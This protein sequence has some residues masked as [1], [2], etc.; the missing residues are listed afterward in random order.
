MSRVIKAAELAKTARISSLFTLACAFSAA[1]IE[2]VS[3]APGVQINNQ[4]QSYYLLGEDPNTVFESISNISSVTTG[5]E[6]G[7]S[8]DQSQVRD[9]AANQLVYFPHTLTNEGNAPDSYDLLAANLLGDQGDLANL[10][11]YLDLNGNGVPDTGELSITQTPVMQAGDELSL[12]V[13]GEV[14][15]GVASGDQFVVDLSATSVADALETA[16]NTDAI[17]VIDGALLR[18]I[19]TSSFAC[20]QPLDGG[21]TF[22]YSVTWTNS[23]DQNPQERQHKVDGSLNSGVLIEDRL[24]ADV[25]LIAGQALSFV[26][27]AAQAVVMTSAD[28]AD[29][30]WISYSSW[31][32]VSHLARI[33]LLIP[34]TELRPTQ[35][36]SF[37]FEVRVSSSVTQNT[38]LEN[39]IVVDEDGD[40]D[41]EFSS[42]IVCNTTNG[43]DAEIRFLSPT[44]ENIIGGD[45]PDFE[46]ASDFSDTLRYR[47]DAD[48]ADYDAT[49]DG[50]YV[51]LS[52]TSVP[53]ENIQYLEDGTRQVVVS[54]NSEISGESVPVLVRETEPGS[55]VY[56]NILPLVLSTTQSATGGLCGDV[57]GE[58]DY[59]SVPPAECVLRSGED[60]SLTVTFFDEG[61]GEVIDDASIVDP[62]GIVFDAITLAPIQGAEVRVFNAINNGPAGLQGELANDPFSA[63]NDPLVIQV[64]DTSGFY[65][66]PFMYPGSYYM[67][68]TLPANSGYAWPSI[69]NPLL[70]PG[71]DVSDFSYGIDGFQGA[72]TDSGVFVLDA[73]NP[74]VSVDFP[75]DP[76]EME[77]VISG[78]VSCDADLTT[79]DPIAYVASFANSGNLTPP[80]RDIQVDGVT[81]TGVVVQAMIPLSTAFD[82]AVVPSFSPVSAELILKLYDGSGPDSWVDYDTWIAQAPEDRLLVSSIGLL[83][84]QADLEPSGT[85]GVLGEGGDL[86]YGVRIVGDITAGTQIINRISVD[87]D[88]N[89]SAD[90]LSADDL[91]DACE[92]VVG[93]EPEIRFLGANNGGTDPVFDQLTSLDDVSQYLLRGVAADYDHSLD[94]VYI[95]LVSTSILAEDF[96]LLDDGRR[97]IRVQVDSGLTGDSIQM[98][99]EETG[100]ASGIYRSIR[101][102]VLDDSDTGNGAVCHPSI[103]ADYV[104]D[105]G[106]ECILTSSVNDVLTVTFLHRFEAGTTTPES[107][108]T[109]DATV[110]PIGFVFFSEAPFDP[111]AGAIVRIY[112][113]GGIP[114]LKTEPTRA[115]ATAADTLVTGPIATAADG[116]FPFPSLPNGAYFLEVESTDIY[117]FPS[118]ANRT[119][120]L[121]ES[122]YRTGAFSYGND[123]AA[124]IIT[125]SDSNPFEVF[126]I[127]VDVIG[128]DAILVV[129]KTVNQNSVEIGGLLEYVVS[130]S[131]VGDGPAS[132]VEVVDRL[133]F[134]FK[135]IENTLRQDQIQIADPNGA[136]APDLSFDVGILLADESIEFRYVL[137]A[138]SGALDSDGINTAQANG[139]ALI[140]PIVSNEARVQVDIELSGVLSEKG[141]I[142]GKIFVDAD[143]NNIQSQGEWPVGGVALYLEDGTYAITDENGQY[144]IYGINPGSHSIK[145]DS[146]TLPEGLKLKPIDNRNLADPDSRLV[147]LING[148]FHRADFA[149]ACPNPSEA[150]FVY[151]QVAARNSSI[152]G[153]WL[154]A[155]SA[156]FDQFERA[157]A[158]AQL[159]DEDLSSGTIFSS[160][161]LDSSASLVSPAIGIRNDL[162][163]TA[164]SEEEVESAVV[165]GD[166]VYEITSEEG[167][168]GLWLWPKDEISLYGRFVVAV[169]D[170][171][172][173]D[174]YLNGEKVSRSQL[175]EEAHNTATDVQ[176]LAWYGL[177]LTSGEN[178]VEVKTQDMFG[179]ERVMLSK[180]FVNPS[181][182]VEL[183]VEPESDIMAA[184]GGRSVMPIQI[185]VLDE[186]GYK[187][188]GLHYVTVE[189]SDGRILGE[190]LQPDTAGFQ[191]RLDRGSARV[192][193]QSSNNT[194]EVE[195]RVSNDEFDQSTF[196][197]LVAAQRSL[198][199][200]GIASA[201]AASCSIDSEGFAP[202]GDECMDSELSN[203]V[204]LFMK[205]SVRGNLFLTLSYDS[206]KAG[207]GELLRDI[208]PDEY[209]PIFGDSSVR[210]YEA[211]SRSKL[212]AKLEMDRS[213][214]QWGDFS[215]DSGSS[216]QDLGRVQRSLTGFSAALDQGSLQA[217]VFIAEVEDTRD[218]IEI[219]GNGTA[220]LFQI[221]AAPIVR[222]SEIIEWVV[223]DRENIGLVLTAETLTR[224]IDYSI[225]HISG[226][227]RFTRAIP[228]VD[229]DLNPISLRISYDLEGATGSDL[230]AGA[231]ASYDISDG[232]TVGASGTK[233]EN[234]TNGFDL[235]SGFVEYKPTE[236]TRVFVSAANMEHVDA[237]LESGNA[238]YAELEMTWENGSN[239]NLRWGSADEGFTNSSAGVSADREELRAKHI[240]KLSETLSLDA[241]LIRSESLSNVESRQ[242]MELGVDYSL[243]D[244]TLSLGGRRI[245]QETGTTAIDDANTIVAGAGRSF[246]LLGRRGNVNLDLE[247]EI[248]EQ[249]RKRWLLG[250]N[251]QA[252]EKLS[253]YGNVEQI[254]SLSSVS[255]LNSN[256]EQVSANFGFE[257]DFL[258]STS[259]FN[260]YR[261]RGISDGQDLEAATGIRGE[262][263]ITE[264]LKVSPSIEWIN[265][266][267][268]TTGQDSFAISLGIEDQRNQNSRSQARIET[269][270]DEGREYYGVDVSYV[271]RTSLNWSLFA[272]EEFS[273][274]ALENSDN[275][276]SHLLTLGLT[277]RPRENNKYH[278]LFMYQ[279]EEQ[280]GADLLDDTSLHLLSTHQNYQFNDKL[281]LSG[282]LGAKYE[283]TPLL[284]EEFSS[285]TAVMD[286]RLI[287]DISR[288]FDF[289]IHSGVLGT[290][291]FDETAYS[292]GLGVNFLVRKGLRVGVGYNLSGFDE[293]DLDTEGYNRQGIYMHAEYKFDED[294]FR[295]LESDLY[296][297][298]EE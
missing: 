78:T 9:S 218:S 23:G 211:Q 152:K 126:D 237:S 210:G 166:I 70:Y 14:P 29:E 216:F 133:P 158:R 197:S 254:N 251:W 214:I 46:T 185:T 54:V 238:L 97:R 226:D 28:Q 181:Q 77:L 44:F 60:D 263:A 86:A 236:Q 258:P 232:L 19:K 11:I 206:D 191:V 198:L 16:T 159:T 47:F 187:A 184:D 122:G 50:V 67:E 93:P 85:P 87:L 243:R 101:P 92:T 160:G 34:A 282:R 55:G 228:T 94:G 168:Q 98:A 131:N 83:I 291:G 138:T 35:S 149:A 84:P 79:D 163:L 41:F 170:R 3:P 61:L 117:A 256:E 169:R 127:P 200:S 201:S 105:P 202:T 262:Y 219:P 281:R 244:W 192:E 231:R 147:D 217:E 106:L 255:A 114:S 111:I 110:A 109:D 42:A 288:R 224:Y 108:L 21:D 172:L 43:P 248:G 220:M 12:V 173:A 186:D 5:A 24:P 165:V 234:A 233:D 205:G 33:G 161:Q 17:N 189:A 194:G 2:V 1:A 38:R 112:E 72:V 20:N 135:Y 139:V 134:G 150:E 280:R 241:E 48:V 49:F 144:S 203:R 213:Y 104:S 6:Y 128:G 148:E 15:A 25:N 154:T 240:Q 271:A 26:P 81:S 227:I 157:A 229:S 37:D 171:V 145:I 107:T 140:G 22:S 71:L 146:L 153:D 221:P 190:D 212:Y 132:M 102:L 275:D 180:T 32:G 56:R 183:M 89:G 193:F 208:D 195:V 277:H 289:D 82:P 75:V 51:E 53:D 137:Q 59:L 63:T 57:F 113:Y 199:V 209:Y 273:Y 274:S 69:R 136:P 96:T 125:I 296:R 250:A 118:E 45:A 286:A 260:E 142:F 116:S 8:L 80:A 177:Q 4:A 175:G 36:G 73:D 115:F 245:E 222:N 207:D 76:V 283:T 239:S 155:N 124:G 298:E 223:R 27:F 100:Y 121:A 10:V 156:S 204:A 120:L 74:I 285:L 129:E 176:V 62:L 99:L 265:V 174:L 246:V 292:F 270:I 247:R 252:N 297:Q 225:D 279:W 179:N 196:I 182:A 52:S 215:T 261:M 257:S 88:G 249:D 141:I 68:V 272:R 65:Q 188:R 167:Q 143:C 103:G 58:V 295:W 293:G 130:V 40:G 264:G 151:S 267:E 235:T 253:I 123:N 13:S 30:D 287:W 266:L 294:M 276:M 268:G 31:D 164:T 284:D 242:S 278:A 66:Y 119:Q 259:V 64:T 91:Q 90:I 162:D 269:R 230:V 178:L 39:Q 7:L 290:N 95:E 18:F